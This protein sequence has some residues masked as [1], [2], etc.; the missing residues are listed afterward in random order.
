INYWM[1]KIEEK[2]IKIFNFKLNTSKIEIKPY[3]SF[4]ILFKINFTINI[5][6]KTE[7]IRIY[8]SGQKSAL[9][10]IEGLEDPLAPLYTQGKY[11]KNIWR[12]PFENNH[13]YQDASNNYH[14]ENL[15]NDTENG[16]F[17]PSLY[18]PS[19]LDRLE[20][21]LVTNYKDSNLIGLESFVNV[22]KLKT[23][24]LTVQTNRTL[25]DF[26]YW[27]SSVKPSCYWLNHQD[28]Q[29]WFRI[30][31]EVDDQQRLMKYQLF[32]N[33]FLNPC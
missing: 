12:C 16:Y 15:A 25:V 10:S 1:E 31:N 27:N 23:L 32:G 2:A 33:P 8:R 9:I 30:D 20:G 3:D 11:K 7:T 4:N 13:V 19:F 5:S 6:D 29:N 21:S 26:L 28:I 22:Q 14:F 18:G 24:G 17:H